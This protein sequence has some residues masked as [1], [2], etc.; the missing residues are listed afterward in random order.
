MQ[1][2]L[3]VDGSLDDR[4]MPR[5]HTCFFALDLPRYTSAATLREKLLYAA[6][7]CSAIDNDSAASGQLFADDGDD[8]P[9]ADNSAD[10]I[11]PF[12]PAEPAGPA[13][14]HKDGG[15]GPF[16]RAG[17][18][19]LAVRDKGRKAACKV[20]GP[21]AAGEWATAPVRYAV[22]WDDGK[23]DGEVDDDAIARAEC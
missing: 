23:Q 16:H 2:K 5:S 8:A 9:A 13:A 3:C 12:Q 20:V 14:A 10:A 18:A 6:R 15:H 21:L 1:F 7:Y 11:L 4:H 17:T 22:R 19:A